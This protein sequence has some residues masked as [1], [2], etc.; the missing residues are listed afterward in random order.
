MLSRTYMAKQN[1]LLIGSD[2]AGFELKER[3]QK[4]LP[5]FHWVDMGT[6]QPQRVDYPDFAAQVARNIAD[7]E[8]GALGVLVCGS[9]I[10]MSISA[11]KID[12]IRAAVVDNPTAAR[13]AREHNNANIVCLGARFT[14]PEYAAEIVETFVRTA[15]ST[16]E[17]HQL[18]VTKIHL[19]EE[20][21]N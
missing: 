16:D 15:F 2:H 17:R 6:T 19:L 7:A 12:G 8:D 5:Q 20:R 13:L 4:M 3:L 1:R 18:R 10:G 11:N 21:S 9:G 14:A